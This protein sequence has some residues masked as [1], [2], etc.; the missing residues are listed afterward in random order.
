VRDESLHDQPS[1]LGAAWQHKWL[2]AAIAG[3]MAV[4]SVGYSVTRPTQFDAVASVVFEDPT[5]ANV[6]GLGLPVSASR[7]VSNELEI[8]RSGAV[9][10]R[11]LELLREQGVD[12]LTL[13]DIRRGAAFVGLPNADVITIAYS[14]DDPATAEAVTSAIID[15][16]REVRS[17]Q[18]TVETEQSVARLDSAEA[19]LEADLRR[20]SA[21]LA[22]L[23]S[24]RDLSSK[25]DTVLDELASVQVSL[26]AASGEQRQSLLVRQGELQSQLQAL[27][28]AFETESQRPDLA[29][30]LRSQSQI[31]D[32]LA[33]LESRRSQIEIEASTRSSGLAFV[34]PP[35]VTDSAPGAGRLFTAL[36]G[37]ALGLLLG[38]GSAYALAVA[39]RRF[40]DRMQPGAVLDLPFL[41]DIP[42]FDE[43]SMETM[44]PV[45]D[46]PRSPVAEAFR[47]AASSLEFRM[48]SAGAKSVMAVSGLVG[49]G[50]ST[51]IANTAIAAARSGR[52][53][54]IIDADFGNQSVSQ[55]LLGDIRLGPG[56]TEL[57]VGKA[58]LH[59][60][61][62]S[63][64][65][66]QGVTVDIVGRG[67]EPVSAPGVFSNPSMRAVLS[68][69]SDVYDLVF[70]D[71]PPLMQVAYGSTLARL[72][73]TTLVVV[74]HGTPVR[75]AEEMRRQLEV[76]E[77][78]SIGYI[79]NRAPVRSEMLVSGGSMKDVLGDRGLVE[80]MPIRKP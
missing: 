47:F 49:D 58:T 70:I 5:A 54:L 19:V 22:A 14:A 4:L 31:F 38:L 34:S 3:S 69:I 53:V 2:V 25:I 16:Y 77:T 67:T 74:P 27:R 64:P 28:L 56:L 1:V 51:L 45:R 65:L 33:D 8:F 75:K 76:V 10:V 79:Y 55:L 40:T 9:A 52:R 46:N 44:L 29:A 73:D 39:R 60:A 57:V 48:E 72:A 61:A 41:A 68:R 63:I 13:S 80:P 71:G 17:V 20:V 23:R 35:A 62:A 50:K 30:L 66:G 15:A 36:A 12:D 59:D 42:R 6:L 26:T 32:K 18:R 24:E 78:P 11:A 37:L 7:T 43:L 21:E